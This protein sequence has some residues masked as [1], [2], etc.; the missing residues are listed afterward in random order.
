MTHKTESKRLKDFRLKLAKEVPIFPNDRP[1]RETLLEMSFQD[2]LIPNFAWRFRF[3]RTAQRQ[4]L[5]DPEAQNDPRWSCYF[6]EI[7]LLLSKVSSGVDI[8]PH[9]SLK[10]HT[11][12][13]TPKNGEVCWEDKDL[14]LNAT[15]FHHFHLGT[16]LEP[17]G[18]VARTDDVLFAQITRDKFRVVGIFNHDVFDYEGPSKM[19]EERSRLWDLYS[20][21]RSEGLPVHS[22]SIAN[23]P[24][25][26][27][28]IP[29]SVVRAAQDSYAI[30]CDIDP[31]LDDKTFRA[32]LSHTDHSCPP[33]LVWAMNVLDLG[34]LDQKASHF[35]ILRRGPN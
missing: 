24:I 21:I 7:K 12:G 10:A 4:I 18:H 26:A 20:R 11:R 29:L 35:F 8:S 33:K 31:K 9:L 25:V 23:K 2:L 6:H 34:L 22:A 32:R 30:I 1:T 3:I 17:K 16:K 5:V 15:G 27:S 19:P 28:G 13:Y 14:I